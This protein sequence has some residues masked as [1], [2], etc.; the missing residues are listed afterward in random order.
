MGNIA[1]ALWHQAESRPSQIAVR[2]PGGTLTY[3]G[4]RESCALVAGELDRRGIRKGD[5]VLLVSPNVPE[6][7]AALRGIQAAGGIAVTANTL[8]TA[9]ELGYIV[10]D[11]GCSLALAWHS[12][13]GA[14]QE[15]CARHG[16]G[17]VLLEPGLSSLGD[18]PG[19]SDAAEVADDDTAVLLY[20]SGTT[21]R[22][23]GAQLTHGN[24]GACARIFHG[25]LG[26]TGDDT[27]GTALPLFHIFGQGVILGAALRA[28]ASLS[29][30]ERFDPDAFVRMLVR[31]R[32]TVAAGVPTMWNAI[33]HGTPGISA[34]S[35]SSLRL[36]ASGG[37]S[38]PEEVLRTFSQR[39]GCMILE[40]YGLTETTGA[41]TF[42]GLD[43]MRKPG[44]VGVALPGCA[45]RVAGPGGR[46]LGTSEV[47]E[48]LVR[49]PVVMKGYWNRPEATAEALRD[50]W[51]STGDLGEIDEDGDLRIVDRT[52]D[53]IIRGGYNV[54]PREVEEVLFGHPDVVEA[55]V[56]GIPDAHY[57]EE[58]GAAVVLRP[59][60]T[61]SM[62][63]LRRWAKERLSAYKVPHR[64]LVM[65]TLPKGSTGKILRRAI[66]RDL[67]AGAVVPGGT[68]AP[69]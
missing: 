50:G 58:V 45:I 14:V 60:S 18:A 20:T 36:A 24:L 2:G 57:G 54:Y 29:I 31:D 33:L 12:T 23:K 5:R 7:V 41:A 38:L 30:L 32:V 16:I 51:L 8:S 37:A 3:G 25:V 52:K 4:L 19:R 59:G 1:A 46:A 6:F 17:T 61:L 56:I 21:G 47:G 69:M 22:P 42:N 28:G 43:R 35:F 48:V 64:L 44:R 39:F 10:S 13:C 65:E 68:G 67:V 27:F 11:A 15:A 9:A 26:L 40:G 62:A 55:A 63:E 53:L 49:G 34:E 66:D